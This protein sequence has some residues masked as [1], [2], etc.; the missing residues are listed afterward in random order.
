MIKQNSFSGEN[1]Y[2]RSTRQQG[3]NDIK[4]DIFK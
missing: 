3:L 1:N 4:V 2:I